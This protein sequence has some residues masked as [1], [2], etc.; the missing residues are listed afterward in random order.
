MGKRRKKRGKRKRKRKRGCGLI[1]VARCVLL[2][3]V[4]TPGHQA[5]LTWNSTAG[6]R[7]T[8]K[9]LGTS[10]TTAPAN[11]GSGCGRRP[12]VVG[13]LKYAPQSPGN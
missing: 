6:R 1:C 13:L 7:C 4:I 3:G 10:A 2:L 12:V 5:N 8:L 9:C 11:A